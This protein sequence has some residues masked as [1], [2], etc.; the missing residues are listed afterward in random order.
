MSNLSV[1]SFHESHEVRVQLIDGQP[2]FC[3]RDVCE[4]LS[5]DRTS[6]LLRDLDEKGVAD[7]HIPTNGGKQ[8][9]KF[10]NEPNLYRIIFRSN[11]PEAKHFQDWVF[12]EVLPTIRQT[13]S[14]HSPKP[15][16]KRDYLTR[17]DMLN[18]K[19]M[20]YW[21]ASGFYGQDSVN[22]AIWYALRQATGVPS[23]AQFEV[24]HMPVISQQMER[25]YKAI[26]VYFKTRQEVE[27]D[28]I[29]RILRSPEPDHFALQSI[30]NDFSLSSQKR[31]N[32]MSEHWH[33]TFGA[34]QK[35][36]LSRQPM[37]YDHVEFSEKPLC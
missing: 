18:L 3:L 12:N 33:K 28:F 26:N 21:I 10:V 23:P 24:Q 19:R 17:S 27:L 2:W 31:S 15:V 16:E 34:D 7:C 30:M 14:Y 20:I 29:K 4:V 25:I 1:F 9:Q 22:K 36:F 11:K 35:R 5:V 6:R 32:Y 37:S 8:S 13:G